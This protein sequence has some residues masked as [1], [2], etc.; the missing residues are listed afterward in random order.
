MPLSKAEAAHLCR[1]VGFGG[2]RAEVNHFAGMEMTD[3]VEEILAVDP[4]SPSAPPGINNPSWWEAVNGMRFWWI[5]RMIDA[6][7][8]NRSADRPSPLEEKLTLFWHSHFATGISKVEDASEIWKQNNIFRNRGRGSFGTL[9]ERVCTSNGALLRYLDNDTNIASNPQENFAREL[10]ELYTTGP[11]EFTENDVI[12]MTRAW[13]GHGIEGW[14]GHWDATYRY[15]G[16]YHDKGTKVLF[17]LAPR[18]W[19][20]PETLSIFTDGVRRDATAR[21]ISTKLWRYFVND[22]PTEAEIDDIVDAFLPN[23]NITNALRAIFTHPTFWDPATE[24]AL[25]RSPVEIIV[26]MLRQLGIDAEDGNFIW[27]LDSL[28]H[29][30]F[31]PPSVAGWGTGDFWIGTG[32]TWAKAQWLISLGWNPQAHSTFDDFL[33]QDSATEA[34]EWA[35]DIL[36]IPRASDETVKAFEHLWTAHNEEHGWRA[37]HNVMILGGMCP[38]MQVA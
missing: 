9:L 18:K 13:T 11:T 35:I 2:T 19:N 14:V 6:R 26:Q 34:A 20:G 23:L 5:D 27:Q 25:V 33:S 10:M 4:T 37:K 32:N 22:D 15:R 7:W 8:T 21:F 36:G 3:A 24:F 38:E 30:I 31:E 16:M 29:Q 12:E 1:R 17:G 28:G